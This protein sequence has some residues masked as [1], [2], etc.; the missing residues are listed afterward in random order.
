MGLRKKTLNYPQLHEKCLIQADLSIVLSLRPPLLEGQQPRDGTAPLQPSL[1]SMDSPQPREE[2]PFPS[3]RWLLG[4]QI[5]INM[6][7]EAPCP[8]L[9]EKDLPRMELI[10]EEN[11][12]GQFC[13]HTAIAKETRLIQPPQKEK[14]IKQKGYENGI[15]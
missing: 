9:Q 5:G 2:G 15:I 6:I 11:N 10:Q 12:L 8:S 13:C 7:Q 14:R 3:Q 1:P 4:K